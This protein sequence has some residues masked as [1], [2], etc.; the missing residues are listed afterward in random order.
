MF[1]KE[2]KPSLVDT[3]LLLYR[4]PIRH[5]HDEVRLQTGRS[6]QRS[7]KY[8]ASRSLLS[9]FCMLSRPPAN[10]FFLIFRN[11]ITPLQAAYLQCRAPLGAPA[12]TGET[13]DERG[14]AGEVIGLEVPIDVETPASSVV[15]VTNC[16]F[17]LFA[18]RPS[19]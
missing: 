9:H 8:F 18:P 10:N 1:R 5:R 6:W 11:V 2:A 4:V 13:D 7:N 15:I 17:I 12:R 3:Y 14:G 19:I 16:L